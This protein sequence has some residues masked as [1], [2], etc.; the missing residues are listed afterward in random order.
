ML[1][2]KKTIVIGALSAALLSAGCAGNRDEVVSIKPQSEPVHEEAPAP[3]LPEKYTASPAAEKEETVSV[4]ADPDGS[5][6]KVQVETILHGAQDDS[7]IEDS[8]ILTDIRNTD[9]AEEFFTLEGNGLV[10][11]NDGKAIH[12]R[13]TSSQPLPVGVSVT[14]Y[15]DGNKAEPSE[16]AGKSGHVRIRFDYHI[17]AVSAQTIDGV[18]YQMKMPFTAVT[19]IPL[20]NH[21]SNVT[22]VNGEVIRFGDTE[23]VV[24]AALPGIQDALRLSD[25]EL[26]EEVNLPEYVELEADVDQFELE[27]TATVFTPGL[28]SNMDE[29]TL[30]DLSEAAGDLNELSEASGKLKDGTKELYDGM[31]EF[32]SYLAEYNS[33]VAGVA[34]GIGALRD[35]L[36]LLDENSDALTD[37]ACTLSEGLKQF[38]DGLAGIDLSSLMP[39][40]SSP[41]QQEMMKQVKAAQEDLPKQIAAIQTAVT[42]LS[43]FT[44]RMASFHTDAEAACTQL[45]NALDTLNSGYVPLTDEEK[46][47]M[48][49]AFESDSEEYRSAEAALN[50]YTAI[51]QMISAVTVPDIPEYDEAALTASLEAF[52]TAAAAFSQDFEILAAYLQSAGEAVSGMEELPAM[53]EKLQT[54]AKQLADGS[55]QLK[56]GIKAYTDGVG[57]VHDGVSQLAEGIGVLPEASSALNEGYDQIL[58]G[59]WSLADGMKEF[60]EKGIHEIAK[61]GSG[62]TKDLIRRAKA[63]RLAD[64]EYGNYAGITEG[65][66][67]SVRFLIETAEIK[68]K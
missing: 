53:V 56:K 65:T 66:E 19:M 36:A 47:A 52:S 16:L 32:R 41:E 29:E 50:Y 49:G 68:N 33:G 34:E 59:T 60:D 10:W 63:L 54:A 45:Q 39:D 57:A 1:N 38:S 3:V 55:S 24:G 27:F 23:A 62:Q 64:C 40:M 30:D 8:S 18:S 7:Y 20:S 5:V 28:F 51:P 6:T 2:K 26:T 31:A 13:G 44:G 42:S 61:L 35:G 48:L 37:G 25:S 21:F 9:G 17:D 12:Y 43:E 22:A 46:A 58:E 14:Y 4:K 15:L 67:G 11:E